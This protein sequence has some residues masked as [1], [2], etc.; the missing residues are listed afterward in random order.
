MH[1]RHIGLNPAIKEVST[2]SN[3]SLEMHLRRK[4]R[5]ITDILF[6]IHPNRNPSL[7]A[8]EY[9]LP[10]RQVPEVAT[11]EFPSQAV[12]SPLVKERKARLRKPQRPAREYTELELPL[13]ERMRKHGIA[14]HKHEE[15]L[16]LEKTDPGRIER[17]ITLLEGII[18]E[19]SE[20]IKNPGAWVVTAIRDNYAA[21]MEPEIVREVKAAQTGGDRTNSSWELES[22]CGG[23]P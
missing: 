5:R 4:N 13:V 15:L 9:F 23:G 7:F 17:N 1:Y 12:T 10:P 2:L 3:I 19:A 22:C 21:T 11:Q 16:A 6:V 20:T 8:P 14:A 18:T